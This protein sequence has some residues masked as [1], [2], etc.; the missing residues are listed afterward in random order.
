M[1]SVLVADALIHRRVVKGE[2]IEGEK[3]H[4]CTK[5]EGFQIEGF[6][7][8]WKSDTV[9][10][11]ALYLGDLETT[12]IHM[13]VDCGRI[14]QEQLQDAFEGFLRCWSTLEKDLKN[15]EF[16]LP[17]RTRIQELLLLKDCDWGWY[18]FPRL[19]EL[20]LCYEGECQPGIFDS[21]P[22]ATIGI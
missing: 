14:R 1:Q 11:V 7:A 17:V 12:H 3:L 20:L 19:L 5:E 16:W 21:G 13:L 9:L 15:W 6:L 10:S 8:L 18:L 22:F 2:V 4:S